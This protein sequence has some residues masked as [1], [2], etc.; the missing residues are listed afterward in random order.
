M[1]FFLPLP[2]T[3]GKQKGGLH[4]LQPET[5]YWYRCSRNIAHFHQGINLARRGVFYEA[6]PLCV[7]WLRGV[8]VSVSMWVKASQKQGAATNQAALT[9]TP[10]EWSQKSPLWPNTSCSF[11]RWGESKLTRK[12]QAI[13]SNKIW[14][15][16][17]YQCT[18]VPGLFLWVFTGQPCREEVHDRSRCQ[19]LLDSVSSSCAFIDCRVAPVSPVSA[20][21]EG[22][23]APLG[24]S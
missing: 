24:T 17:Q 22:T 2:T 11:W 4:S 6:R 7:G 20:I 8:N 16:G 21:C 18:R 14:C 5:L 1:D 12:Q 23:L 15:G 9:C 13:D 3:E 19:A 10:V